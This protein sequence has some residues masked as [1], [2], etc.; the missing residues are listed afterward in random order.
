MEDM[1][2]RAF[3]TGALVT[4]SLGAAHAGALTAAVATPMAEGG[5][6]GELEPADANGIRL[7]AGFTSRVVATSGEPVPGTGF[8]WHRAPDGAA[9]FPVPGGFVLVSNSEVSGTGGVGAIHFDR[10]GTIVDAYSILS[11][12]SINC[13]GGVTP[14]GTWLSCEEIVGGLVYE[15]D[16]TKAGQGI[17][18]PKLGE[19]V[20]EAVTVDSFRKQLYLSQDI[21]QSRFWRFTPSNWRDDGVGVLDDGVLETLRVDGAGNVTWADHRTNG[22]STFNGG[23]GIWYDRGFVYLATKGDG[24][25]W[26]LDVHAQRLEVFYDRAPVGPAPNSPLGVDG[27]LVS[28]NGDLF[29]SEDASRVRLGVVRR[30]DRPDRLWPRR[31]GLVQPVPRPRPD[32][33]GPADG[34][35]RTSDGRPRRG[36]GERDSRPADERSHVL[37]GRRPLLRRR[38]VSVPHARR[39]GLPN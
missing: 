25:I 28:P 6:Y 4:G 12:T 3:L 2:R 9:T 11:G 30:H 16:P 35:A 38:N 20:H 27:L 26:A 10:D 19:F 13:A 33:H 23:E 17:P 1:Q 21:P 32:V 7:P 39:A 18:R 36:L 14:W 5:P 24:R 34:R 31:A 29:V 15:C 8:E 22:A 37:Q